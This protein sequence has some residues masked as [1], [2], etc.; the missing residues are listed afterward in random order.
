MG[1]PMG[2]VG[3]RVPWMAGHAGVLR[4]DLTEF[5]G[6]PESNPGV[7]RPGSNA[8]AQGLPGMTVYLDMTVHL[9]V[10]VCLGDGVSRHDGVLR[11][12]G[13]PSVTA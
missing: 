6:L 1:L 10:T 7:K 2:G 5:V 11:R 8:L 13:V 4:L 9:R 12:G 3:P